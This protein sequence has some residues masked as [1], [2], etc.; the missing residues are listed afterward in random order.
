MVSD[1]LGGSAEGSGINVVAWIVL[2]GL[3]KTTGG[4]NTLGRV[5]GDFRS[6]G[7]FDSWMMSGGEV[8]KEAIVFEVG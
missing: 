1:T 4:F 8:G 7:R 3:G 5:S 6:P 2:V